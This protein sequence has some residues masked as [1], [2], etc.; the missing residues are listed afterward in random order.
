MVTTLKAESTE[1][2][3]NADSS[4]WCQ[5]TLQ[6]H[7]QKFKL[8]AETLPILVQRLQQALI[9]P[10]EGNP[11]GSILG[12]EV[13]WVMTLAEQ[14]CTIYAGNVEQAGANAPNRQLFFQDSDGV[15]LA[16][17]TLNDGTRTAWAKQLQALPT[18]AIHS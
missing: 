17:V 16:Q 12:T 9:A 7:H 11:A 14:H 5:L 10:L 15:L 1:L 6:S 3:L 8:G 13:H 4:N 2:T 18:R